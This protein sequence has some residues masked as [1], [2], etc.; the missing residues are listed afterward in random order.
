V[1]FPRKAVVN[2]LLAAGLVFLSWGGLPAGEAGGLRRPAKVT[3]V[4][5]QAKVELVDLPI[6]PTQRITYQFSQNMRMGFQ[7][8]T[9]QGLVRITCGQGGETNNT[10]CRIDNT[11]LEFGNP[12]GRWD[13]QQAPLAQESGGRKRLGTKSTWVYSNVRITQIVEVVATR[14]LVKKDG[15][16]GKRLRDTC[17]IR[18]LIENKDTRP[19]KVG[20][21]NMIDTLIVNNDGAQFAVPGKDA[22]ILPNGDFRST[23]EIPPYVMVLERPDLNNPGVM[24]IVSPRLGGRIDPPNRLILTR[25]PGSGVGWEVPVQQA[26]FDTAYAIYWDPK[27]IPAGGKREVGHAYGRGLV[28]GLEGEGRVQV[29]LGGSFQPGKRFTVTA[30][31][32][33]PEE[34]QSLTLELPAGMARLEGKAVQP[35]PPPLAGGLSVVLW[36]GSVERTGQFPLRVRSSTGY[37]LTKTVSV[38]AGTD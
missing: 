15:A 24:A 31:V 18:Y 37:I 29:D 28:T 27:E 10:T 12:A 11:D 23:K 21:R 5:E 20:I 22:R 7:L 16:P 26:A 34:G 36:K 13:P 6:D 35:V 38:T 19:H 4:D 2:L 30:Y 8:H 14:P 3:V 33:S 17:V 32:E 9:E 1:T 25:W